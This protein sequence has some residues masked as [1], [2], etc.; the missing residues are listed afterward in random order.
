[1]SAYFER[2]I[3][4]CTIIYYPIFSCYASLYF[5]NPWCLCL[6]FFSF[7]KIRNEPFTIQ[8]FNC[9]PY[10]STNFLPHSWIANTKEIIFSVKKIFS[11]LKTLKKLL[12]VKIFKKD[13]ACQRTPFCVHVLNFKNTCYFKY[14]YKSSQI[15][16]ASK[17]TVSVFAI[18]CLIDFNF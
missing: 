9:I 14:F 4:F 17:L 11:D 6:E 18:K 5:F 7:N 1:M 15:K 12:F 10:F 13:T 2:V 3:L 16:R 8:C